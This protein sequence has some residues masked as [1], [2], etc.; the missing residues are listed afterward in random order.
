MIDQKAEHEAQ[1]KAEHEKEI[2]LN[3]EHDIILEAEKDLGLKESVTVFT[4]TALKGIKDKLW[5]WGC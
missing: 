5:G 3:R 1:L 4:L 2:K